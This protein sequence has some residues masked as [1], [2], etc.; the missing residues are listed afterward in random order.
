MNDYE[1]ASI[2]DESN[3]LSGVSHMDNEDF[4]SVLGSSDIITARTMRGILD[5]NGTSAYLQPSTHTDEADP[6][7]DASMGF[8]RY[9]S[10]EPLIQVQGLT[11]CTTRSS[12]YHANTLGSQLN[13]PGWTH[14]LS[15]ENDRNLREYLEFG[16][17]E[18]FFIVDQHV[19]IPS[20]HAK[21]Y[22]SVTQ[23]EAHTFIDDLINS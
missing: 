16:V 18:G 22:F 13:I 23:G 4:R 8:N 5:R 3:G 19:V 7:Y 15:Y 14:E 11:C 9:C 2:V 17:Q 10:Y 1:Y 20:Y 6:I 21:N 12:S